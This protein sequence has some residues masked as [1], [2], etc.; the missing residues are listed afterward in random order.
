MTIPPFINTTTTTTITNPTTN[1][2]NNNNNNQLREMC[3]G[4]NGA[5]TGGD[6]GNNEMII[7]SSHFRIP[8]HNY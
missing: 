4:K 1:N 3:D 2:N 6:R 8:Y 5:T 7:Y